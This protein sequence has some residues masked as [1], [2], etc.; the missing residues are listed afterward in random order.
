MALPK[1]HM[2][3]KATVH[4]VLPYALFGALWILLSDTLLEVMVQDQALFT[5]L[6]IYKGWLF[7]GVTSVMLAALM[8]NQLGKR[9]A[10]FD[11]LEQR[12]A[13]RTRALAEAVHEA[14]SSDRLK[15]VF[16]ATMSHELR[17]PLNSIIGFTGL[18]LQEL[19]GALN[20]EQKKQLGMVR[21][22][23]RHLLRLINDVLDISKI[24]AGELKLSLESFDLGASVRKVVGIMAP[25]AESKGLLLR[26]DGAGDAGTMTGDERR[27]EQ[28]LMNLLSN[29]IKFTSSG[30]VGL[31]V[32]HIA[33]C[34]EL[35]GEPRRPAI[36]LSVADTGIGIGED[37]IG[38]VFHPFRQIDSALTRQHDGTG[39]GL[40][41]CQQ[42]VALMGGKIGVQSQLGEGS[43]FTVTL[44]LDGPGDGR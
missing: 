11:Q 18:L 9:Q 20:G 14:E 16:L 40:A 36:R 25:L 10:A 2:I 5:R 33:E 27:V 13:E 12:V 6:S 26:V 35:P 37:H 29:A 28:I 44:P 34:H 41:I 17:T 24:E 7:V 1:N 32:E 22:S 19:P 4:L 15:S 42:L 21:N 3:S 30:T 43:V 23:A 8:A 39:L 38:Y 31:S